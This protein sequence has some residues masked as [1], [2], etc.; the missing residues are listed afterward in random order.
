MFDQETA[1][2]M[3]EL[4]DIDSVSSNEQAISEV[5]RNYY[6]SHELADEVVYDNL[7]SIYALKKS[8]QKNAP[9]VMVSGHMDEVGF[10]VTR[11]KENGIIQALILGEIPKQSLLATSVRLTTQSK[12]SYQ[13]V[14][15]NNKLDNTVVD[16]NN[17][18]QIDFGFSNDHAAVKSDIQLGDYISYDATSVVGQSDGLMSK[19]WNGRYAPIVGIQ[20]LQAI[21]D[22]TLP[23]DLYVG[24]TVQEQVGLR[25]I[26]TATNKIAPDLAII[27]DTDQAYDYQSNLDEKNG[28]LGKGLLLTYY[29]KTVLPNRLLLNTLKQICVDNEIAY[30][31][32]Y[33]MADSDA[34]WVNKLRTG[35]PSLFINIPVR[36]LNTARSIIYKQDYLAAR[37]ALIKFIKSITVQDIESFK[38]ENR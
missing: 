28:I 36:N 14:I 31:Y 8:H 15:L 27:T 7:G 17:N 6:M 29:D 34:G 13:G 5:L 32:Y 20:L 3:Q 25:G 12:K 35:C 16:S 24:C 21:K 38:T 9:R 19:N 37:E 23:F 30:Q 11:I 33:S 2:L 22:I 18:I 10:I 26:Q 4:C 1:E